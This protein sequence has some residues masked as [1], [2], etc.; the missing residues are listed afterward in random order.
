MNELKPEDVMKALERMA[1][2][3]NCNHMRHLEGC[4]YFCIRLGKNV[5]DMAKGRSPECN[6]NCE[7]FAPPYIEQVL[8][9]AIA[10]LRE[11]DA[12]IER[13]REIIVK[14]DYSSYTARLA[15]ESWHRNNLERI[16]RL[17]A[18]IERLTVYNANLICA[19]TDITNRHKD[20]VEEAERIAR[21]DAITEFAKRAKSEVNGGQFAS[22]KGLEIRNVIDQIAKEM[23]E[24]KG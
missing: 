7:H 21:A 24:G 16:R 5:D 1:S 6:E 12:E 9:S 17:E 13:L 10:L 2:K 4:G 23:K 22:Y 11:K 8:R 19:N 18:E 3:A 20:Y 15:T 14:G